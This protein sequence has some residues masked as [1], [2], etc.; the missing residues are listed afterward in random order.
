MDRT[1]CEDPARQYSGDQGIYPGL[2]KPAAFLALYNPARDPVAYINRERH[3]CGV[4]PIAPLYA[5]SRTPSF[6]YEQVARAGA[7]TVSYWCHRDK[8]S[9]LDTTPEY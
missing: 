3:I 8:T 7:F 9:Q 5:I 2:Q 6:V 1:T 4:A